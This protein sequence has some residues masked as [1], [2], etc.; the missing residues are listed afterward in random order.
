MRVRH[1]V[2]PVPSNYT[3]LSN[4]KWRNYYLR[5]IWEVN[6]TGELKCVNEEKLKEQ[7]SIMSYVVNKMA[8]NL[9]TG[10]SILNVSLPVSIFS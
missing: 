5:D 9:F 1:A 8:A 7:H 6:S 4:P 2:K 3:K 10:K